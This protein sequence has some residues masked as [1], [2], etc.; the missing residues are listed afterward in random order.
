MAVANTAN[1]LSVDG[2]AVTVLATD[3][4]YQGGHV[5][6]FVATEPGVA[7]HIFASSGR[8]NRRLY[9][10]PA[11]E[12]WVAAHCEE[13]DLL[14]VQGIWSASGI[15]VAKIFREHRKPYV[16]TPHGTMTRYD[17]QKS[18]LRRELFFRL[19]FAKVWEEADAI[20]FLSQGEAAASYYPARDFFAVIPNGIE[21]EASPT[22][23]VQ[24]AA[25]E[26]LGIPAETRV[27]LFLGR[28]THQKGVKE[29]LAA[30]ELAAAKFPDLLL[31]LVG[32]L[33]GDLR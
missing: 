32:P 15:A 2:H 22:R 6:R 7:V 24:E 3:C 9:R 13:F 18:T 4:G 8:L 20:R 17:W 21:L 23:D 28:I 16:L 10:S 25:R 12:Q 19:G 11:L 14:D 33:E 26:R 27:L 1:H 29:A 31:L 5:S 30:Y